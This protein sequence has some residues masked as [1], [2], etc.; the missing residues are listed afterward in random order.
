L[1]K[2]I[3]ASK[4]IAPL[5]AALNIFSMN[6]SAFAKSENTSV[7][8]S[9]DDKDIGEKKNNKK[10]GKQLNNVLRVTKVFALGAT[11]YTAFRVIKIL[12]RFD[13][14]FNEVN[15]ILSKIDREKLKNVI[16]G[17]DFILK[18][19]EHRLGGSVP[20]SKKNDISEEIIK[21]LSEI[22]TQELSL[23]QLVLLDFYKGGSLDKILNDKT[24]IGRNVLSVINELK[25]FLEKDG[26]IIKKL[27]VGK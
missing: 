11:V 22:P 3:F 15:D 9:N 27:L 12:Q 25:V 26:S 18:K 8:R 7:V 14:T 21:R 5:F 19:P 24:E 16:N 4:F 17:I 20:D 10:Y 2:N 23:L 13:Q 6:N 1:K